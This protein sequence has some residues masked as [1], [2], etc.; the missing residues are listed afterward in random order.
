MKMLAEIKF[1]TTQL[2]PASQ[3]KPLI[4]DVKINGTVI[5]Y[6]TIDAEKLSKNDKTACEIIYPDGAV[7][8]AYNCPR[9]AINALM[10]SH[11]NLPEDVLTTSIGEE[12]SP[13]IEILKLVLGTQSVNEK[14]PH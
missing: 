14:S 3:G 7:L 6:L 4:G 9:C 13:A 12:E 2:F 5:A 8:G 11:F 10:Q 1:S